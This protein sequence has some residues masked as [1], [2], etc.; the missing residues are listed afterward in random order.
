MS[1]CGSTDHGVLMTFGMLFQAMILGNPLYPLSKRSP[2]T[3]HSVC[4]LEE[5]R[6][7]K[8]EEESEALGE[9]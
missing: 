2:F 7:A 8:L 4:R 5:E 1:H 6:K 9:R 3:Q